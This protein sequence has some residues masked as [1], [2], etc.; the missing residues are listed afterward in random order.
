MD[1][2]KKKYKNVENKKVST[3]DQKNIE[4]KINKITNLEGENNEKE[5]IDYINSNQNIEK[6]NINDIN[7]EN[8]TEESIDSKSVELTVVK[9]INLNYDK[10]L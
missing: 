2:L 1:K 5:N 4:K 3:Q 9:T 6:E 10:N 7:N 8:F